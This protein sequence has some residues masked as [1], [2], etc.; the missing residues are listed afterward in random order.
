MVNGG[1]QTKCIIQFIQK[2]LG[3]HNCA[4][5]YLEKRAHF[6]LYIAK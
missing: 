3:L 2:N 1:L 6:D 5:D 4:S